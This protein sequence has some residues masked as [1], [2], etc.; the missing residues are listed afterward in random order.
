MADRITTIRLTTE[1]DELI[2]GLSRS[3]G[4]STTTDVLRY[5]LRIAAQHA[6]VG[7]H[8]PA[9]Q[10]QPPRK[11]ASRRSRGKVR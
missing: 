2:A 3:T 11:V 6:G 10:I 4:I 5:A 1:D 7:S 8:G 9:R